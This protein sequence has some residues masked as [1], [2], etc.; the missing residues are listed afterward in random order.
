M[1]GF[2]ETARERKDR[3]RWEAED[4][5]RTLVKAMEIGNDSGRMKRAKKLAD[6]QAKELKAVQ[7]G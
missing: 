3:Q 1:P 7:N 5:L 4:D 6:L 2:K